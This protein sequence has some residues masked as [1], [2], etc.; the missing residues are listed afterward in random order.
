MGLSLWHVILILLVILVPL[1]SAALAIRIHDNTSTLS[2]SAFLMR[3][4]AFIIV[5]LLGEQILDF[6]S[7]SMSYVRLLAAIAVVTVGA[8][9]VAHWCVSRMRNAGIHAKW[10][11]LLSAIP[12]LGAFFVIYLAFARPQ[13]TAAIAETG[14]S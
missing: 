10:R 12:L 11:A 6:L 13:T 1:G 3:I 14:A 7:P 2:R 8:A 5:I 9:L 4:G